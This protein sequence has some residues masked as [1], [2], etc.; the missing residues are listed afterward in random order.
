MN[1]DRF[2]TF[3]EKLKE[4]TTE[5]NTN[6]IDIYTPF[7]TDKGV[8]N[9]IYFNDMYLYGNGYLKLTEILK[10]LLKH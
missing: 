7:V 8:C 4:L 10:P 9:A 1:D 5:K 3:N 6:F 2:K